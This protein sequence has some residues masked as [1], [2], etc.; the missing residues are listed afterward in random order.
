MITNLT[1]IN[2]K[3]NTHIAPSQGEVFLLKTCQRTLIVGI[4]QLPFSYLKDNALRNDLVTGVYKGL[5]AYTFL[6]ETI[7]GLHS[8]ILAEYEVVSQ[9]KDAYK[10]YL[11]APVRQS[12]M[13]KLLEKLFQDMKKVRTAHLTGIGQLSYAGIARKIIHTNVK[14]SDVLILGSGTLAKDVALLL[15]KNHRIFVSARNQKTL[16]SLKNSVEINTVP[17]EKKESYHQFSSIVNTVGSN[18]T[19]LDDSFFNAFFSINTLDKHETKLFIDLGSPSAINTSRSSDDGVW[20]L[21]DV[22][23]KSAVLGQEKM[24]KIK[25]AK[26]LIMELSQNR[27]RPKANLVLAATYALNM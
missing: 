25:E 23:K 24:D 4:G 17:W 14:S 12:F 6:L 21:E 22:F 27:L 11:Q 19:I 10:N 16:E 2:L 3:A 13:I 1:V 5:E 9:F 26:A 7:C 8:E 20:R 18:E 15:K